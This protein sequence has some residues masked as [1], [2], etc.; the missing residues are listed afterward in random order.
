MDA[1][2]QKYNM[3]D[4]KDSNNI[5]TSMESFPPL[6]HSLYR[7]EIRCEKE[8]KSKESSKKSK[9]EIVNLSVKIP[10]IESPDIVWIGNEKTTWMY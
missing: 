3:Y 1:P 10:K 8:G 4:C 9:C 5:Y 6:P 7:I 2:F